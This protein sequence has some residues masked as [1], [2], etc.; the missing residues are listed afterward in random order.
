MERSMNASHDVRPKLRK[1]AAEMLKK[2]PPSAREALL[3]KCWIS[4]DA[5][6]FMAVA[7][8]YG[9]PA[10][11]RLN[12][13]AAHEVGK[14]EARRLMRALELAP[15]TTREAYLLTQELLIGLLGP[16]LI[17]YSVHMLNGD[18]FE[19][20]V[21]RCFA[22][23]NTVTAGISDQ[24]ECG[25]WARVTGWME[26]LEL[27]YSLS[28]PLGKCLMAQGEDCAYRITLSPRAGT[29]R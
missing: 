14:V 10:A 6:W 20:R 16:D 23:E 18:T 27:N 24:V 9:M 15:V 3:I 13:I 8:E 5:R 1:Q 4:H 26:S 22:H 19:V 17:D 21:S 25:V 2:L 28:P 7:K 12:K 11:N 29:S